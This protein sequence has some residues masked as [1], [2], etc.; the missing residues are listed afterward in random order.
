MMKN[1]VKKNQKIP[2]L[3]ML[4]LLA[5]MSASA[6]FQVKGTVVS[7]NDS[8][9]MIGV[10]ILENGTHNGC[11]TDLNGNYSISVES[12]NATLEA[13]FI[14]YKSQTV[15]VSGRNVINFRLEEDTEVLDEVVVV[16][17]GTMEK[18]RVTSAIT[19]ISADDM[20]SGLGGATI[21]TALQGKISGLTT[22]GSASPNASN[23]Y[24]LRGV[25]SVNAGQGPLVVIDGIPGGDLRA[26]NQE[27]IQSIDVLKDAS[28][29]A[30]YGTRAAAGVI[31]VTTK[32]AKEG[33]TQVNYSCEL[34]IESVR[35]HLDLL[36]S[37]EYIER[38]LGQDYGYDTDWYKELTRDNPLSQRHV[39]TISGGTKDLQLY[40]S[41][42]YSDQQGIVR[43]DGRTDYSA[44]LNGRYSM[45]DG[46]A[47]ISMKAQFRQAD[48]DKRNGSYTFQKAIEL[49]PTIPLWDPE[50]PSNY[51]VSGPGM[52][53]NSWNPVADI[54]YKDYSAKDQ[55][56]LG[57][58]TLKLNLMKGLSVQGTMGLDLRQYQYNLY[59][60][61]KHNESVTSSK[62][63][64]ATHEFSKSLNK[65]FEAYANYM[66]EFGDHFIDAV[67][68]YSFY[69]NEGTES[70]EMTNAN[71]TVDG[72]GP[73]DMSAGTDLSD[74]QASMESNKNP[75]QRLLS[76]F[77]RANYSYA[78]K[79]MATVSYRREG[80]SKFGKNNRWG[81]FWSVSGGWRISNETF[82]RDVRW[83]NDL[84]VRLGYGV[85]GNNGFGNGYTT[86][87][88]KANDMWPTNGIWQ[89][90][91][92]SV[93]NVNPDLKWE[94]K[95]ELNFGL[96]FSL[97]DDRLWGKFDIYHRKVD[98]MLYEVNAPMPPMVH[99]TV[100]K[101]IG[102]LENKGWEFE[103][104]GD[105]VR[106]KNFR[107]TS[108]L[109]L[110]H[111]KSKIKRLGDDGYF[112]DQVTFPSPGNP[113]T[114]VRLQNGVEIGQFFVYK[115]AG[116][117]EDGKWMIYDKNNEI[118]PAVDGTKSN[119]VAENKHFVGNAIPKVIL[120]WDH[121]F[122]YKNWDLS[123]F[124][125]SWLDYDVFS[126]VNM[127]YGLANDSQLN[128]LKS[129]YTRNRNI[130]DEKILCDYWIDDASFLKIDAIN[131][132]YTL[133]LKRWT[134]YIQSAKIYLTIRD[135]AVFTDYNGIN[136]EVDI[137]G[138]NPG[139]EYVNNTAS[140]YPQTTRFTLGVQLTF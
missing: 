60:S 27:D 137:N 3:F 59:Y 93:R 28:A 21:A 22:T 118:V 69:E 140:M 101:N 47:E 89:P 99:D 106:S 82:L 138:L 58:A 54:E 79:Y 135:V 129:A 120:S 104:G 36:S 67:A 97:F 26:I 95:S 102:S 133:D 76:F 41:L 5:C 122:R 130:K 51:N 108:S 35:K 105:I 78:D 74:G 61:Q 132:G 92:G 45:W 10:T 86:R 6:Q 40:S 73:W 25:A 71:F 128:V 53:G 113:G 50:N 84:K 87:M 12:S 65:S 119:L 2:F 123:V 100:M 109:R 31:L 127:Y 44:R 34:S 124:L 81:N 32:K 121:T 85:T 46:V 14:G 116:L 64:K 75:R 125:R 9:P 91:Y 70:F 111:N 23:G 13:S 24:Q 139:F 62:R 11:I 88:Y 42:M 18:K 83:V 8:E 37:Q 48:R 114:A 30:I 134:R 63:G 117:D 68:G 29:G 77:G 7:A 16:G 4:M 126:Q 56:F 1:V 55:W 112:L 43:G 107:Y 96:D 94:E 72:I 15:K 98:D 66:R 20:M 38:G 33:K 90:G 80:S 110:S 49:N 136:P 103:L 131:L 52:G 19:S 57:D 115:Y 17:Y 39:L